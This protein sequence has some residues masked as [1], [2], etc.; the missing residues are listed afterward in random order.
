VPAVL[1][2]AGYE[3]FFP[4]D[5]IDPAN[6]GPDQYRVRTTIAA[7][8]EIYLWHDRLVFLPAVHW[9]WIR[10]DF[11]GG[12]PANLPSVAQPRSQTDSFASPRLGGAF[13]LVPGL[14]VLANVG[15]AHRSPSFGELFGDRGVVTGN[16]DLSPEN[17]TKWDVGFRFRRAGLGPFSDLRFEYAYFDSDFDDLIVLV[18][19]SQSVLSPENIG[20]ARITGNEVSSS[21]RVWRHVLLAANYTQQDA[22]D[23]GVEPAF[24]GQRLPGRPE[25]EA[26]LRAELYNDWGRFA[27]E[28]SWIGDNFRDRGERDRIS[29]RNLQSLTLSVTPPRTGLGVT[30]EVKNLTDD[31]TSDFAGFPLPGRSFFGT[32]QYRF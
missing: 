11:T 6:A 18:P 5:S 10:D 21:I 26:Y 20:S 1:L 13:R 14:E 23:E 16:P 30:F 2:A 25:H 27:Y 7:Q 31:Q 19:R 24:R 15:H 22:T 3:E 28:I 17:V 32:V 9:D 29:S 12:V 4:D 8:N